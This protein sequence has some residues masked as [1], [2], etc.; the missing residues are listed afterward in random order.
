[1][2]FGETREKLPGLLCGVGGGMVGAIS[3]GRDCFPLD[4]PRVEMTTLA[5]SVKRAEANPNEAERLHR[6]FSP[7]HSAVR[8][9]KEDPEAL[10]RLRTLIRLQSCNILTHP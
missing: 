9:R 8:S 4:K 3:C 10:L 2:L 7:T 1:M 6:N 5:R